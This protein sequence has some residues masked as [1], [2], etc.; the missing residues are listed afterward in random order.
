MRATLNSYRVGAKA[1]GL[2]IS[3]AVALCLPQAAGAET[4]EFPEDELAAESVL[5]VFDRPE[6]VKNR[7][8]L[9]ANRIELG[10]LGG[11]SLTE[12]FFNPL[13]VGATGTYHI[14]ETSGLNL[15]YDYYLQGISSYAKQLN[16]IPKTNNN[17]NLQYAPA[18]KSLFLASYQ[19]T[20][21]YGKISVAKDYVMNLGLYGLAG[22]G[23]ITVGDVTKPA[24]SV[25]L[26]QK[27]YLS[28]D[29]A[30]RFDL[31]LLGYKGPDV[32]SYRL[33]SANEIQPA[34]KFEEKLNY[35]TLLSFGAVYL[36]PAF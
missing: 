15:F 19:Y 27:F 23:A 35:Q 12:P 18:P 21:Y 30:L 11:Y 10:A 13:S 9:T 28:K 8:V 20:A 17:M 22:V 24:A 34:S 16:P 31:R 25:G 7:N 2:S 1:L 5:P 4:I 36:L 33:V 26:G 32:L 3:V 29:F 14:N 6:A